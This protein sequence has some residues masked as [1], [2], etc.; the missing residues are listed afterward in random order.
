MKIAVGLEY[1]GAE[2]SGWQS[3][4][5][6]RTVQDSLQGALSKV[7]DHAVTVS[8][9]GRTDSGVH[10][11]GQVAH[12]DTKAERSSRSWVLGTNV[13]LPPAI[14]VT[15]A[16]PVA[17]SFHARFGAI[18]RRYRYI[19]L[20][21]WARP[22]VLRTKVTWQRQPLD[23]HRMQQAA[24]HLLGEHD[25][26][27]FRAL[28]CQAKNP[29]RRVHEL[30]VSREADFVYIDMHANAFLYHMVRNIAGVLMTIGA[31]EQ[32]LRWT[33][34]LLQ[35]RDRARGGITAP[36][37]GLYLV[38]IAYPPQFGL[39]GETALPRYG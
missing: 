33:A 32:S 16:R 6:A 21:R 18:S 10:A 23:E 26:T 39:P 20:N 25:F 36:P 11:F 9:A 31:G 34:D 12:F 3:Q 13:N 27:S 7:A 19:I 28:A 8:C 2:F 24:T 35:L 14:T 17:E 15:W 38:H 22:A 1:D 4:P 29:V 37:D 30:S 5:S